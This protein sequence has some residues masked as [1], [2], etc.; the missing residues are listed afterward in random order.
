MVI[1]K[2]KAWKVYNDDVQRLEN[3]AYQFKKQSFLYHPPNLNCNPQTD[4]FKRSKHHKIR[5]CLWA[6]L[7]EIDLRFF[8]FK[9]PVLIKMYETTKRKR[10]HQ[11]LIN[12]ILGWSTKV[13]VW[14][15]SQCEAYF[16]ISKAFF[17]EITMNASIDI[18]IYSAQYEVT[19]K[20]YTEWMIDELHSAK[21][22][23]H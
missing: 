5:Q 12:V 13:R 8:S 2:R 18:Y 3:N 15:L 9:W 21:Y 23:M 20:I 7:T 17:D 16:T 14:T 10:N 6:F 1:F 11:H 4:D 22:L 19:M